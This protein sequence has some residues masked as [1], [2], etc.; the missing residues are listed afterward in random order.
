MINSG[1]AIREFI[2]EN[3]HLFKMQMKACRNTV[4]KSLSSSREDD[5]DWFKGKHSTHTLIMIHFQLGHFPNIAG[6][7]TNLNTKE[8]VM[9]RR[10]QDRVR[11]YLYKTKDELTSAQ[12]YKTNKK[13]REMIDLLVEIFK[14][15]LTGVDY[16]G[17][18]F[19]RQC[20]NRH[21]SVIQ[22]TKLVD[23]TIDGET[24]R[25]KLK[26]NLKQLI[27]EHNL[28]ENLCVSLCTEEGD[29]ICQGIWNRADCQYDDHT[30]NPYASRENA[31][32][33]QSWNL[34]HQIEIS[35]AILPSL[36]DKVAEIVS[37]K[38]VMCPTHNRRCVNVSVLTYF[39]EIFTI[40]NLKF[41]HIVCHDKGAHELKSNG[42]VICEMCEE[43]TFLK[44]I[45]RLFARK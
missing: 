31:I 29:F 25:K 32:L 44:Q 21:P 10:S 42:Y 7:P 19:D 13:A 36:I 8:K 17:T 41:V 37:S 24:P 20:A 18:Y 14:H 27:D 3:R 39:F 6:Q 35:R 40:K 45:M 4:G 28:S 5:A 26:E 9:F 22:F 12:L 1:N 33:F 43:Y 16:F 30:I 34:D 15:L 23:D 38:R 11:G 2:Y